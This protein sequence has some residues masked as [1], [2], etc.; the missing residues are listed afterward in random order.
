MDTVEAIIDFWVGPLG[1]EG[2]GNK[3]GVERWF[4]PDPA[5]DAELTRRFGEELAAAERGER[6]EWRESRRG[7]LAYVILLDQFSR[8]IYRKSPRMFQ[9]DARA[10]ACA[11]RALALGD[12][13]NLRPE[14]RVFL[15][16]PLMHSEDLAAQNECVAYFEA[17]RAASEGAAA[18]TLGDM[19]YFAR[20]HHEIIERFGRYPHRNE[21]LGRATTPEE[22][23]FL[24]EKDSSF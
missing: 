16:M 15:Y 8:N 1:P 9:N 12:A 11:R 3:A 22:A 13:E 4:K 14:E 23:Q 21:L 20:R 5:L 7:R 6:D 17:L 18:R 19:L 2:L 10:L 24:T